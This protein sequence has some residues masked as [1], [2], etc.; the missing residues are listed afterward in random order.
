MPQTLIEKLTSLIRS[1]LLREQLWQRW[2]PYWKWRRLLA[3]LQ[4][5]VLRWYFVAHNRATARLLSTRLF[6]SIFRSVVGPALVAV[7]TIGILSF[8]ERYLHDRGIWLP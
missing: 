6:I 5:Q 4:W 8:V 3:V 7:L 2:A 1:P